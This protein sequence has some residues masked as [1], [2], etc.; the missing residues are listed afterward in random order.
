MKISFLIFILLLFSFSVLAQKEANIWIF[1]ENAGLDFNFGTPTPFVSQFFGWEGCSSIADS[2]GSLLF[3]SNGEKV[4]NKNGVIMDNGDSL[5]GGMSAVQSCLIVKIPNSDSLYYLFTVD[6]GENNG[7]NGFRYS[8]IDVSLNGGLGKVVLRDQLLFSPTT[9]KIA[10]THSANG[11]DV[12]V[13]GHGLYNDEFYAYYIDSNGIDTVPVVSATGTVY[14]LMESAGQIKVSHDGSRLATVGYKTV[15]LYN[16]DKVTGIISNTISWDYSDPNLYLYG[17]EFSPNSQVLY[18][19]TYPPS[20]ETYQYDLSLE[21]DSVFY[22]E[23]LL[24]SQEDIHGGGLQLAPDGKIYRA[25]SGLFAGFGTGEYL[26]VV[27]YPNIVGL[28]CSFNPNGVLL[29]TNTTCYLS[30]PT[31]IAS[32]L[33]I[34]TS[35]DSKTDFQNDKIFPVPCTDKVSIDF[36]QHSNNKVQIISIAGQL[37]YSST[38]KDGFAEIDVSQFACGIYFLKVINDSRSSVQT[39]VKQ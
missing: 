17:V 27:N 33:L 28:G 26:G 24:E 9:E 23:V 31:I 3:Y 2:N 19:S 14:N 4:W 12:W 8:L 32:S 21:P 37:V 16:F 38:H 1:G 11:A 30:L 13:I 10:A 34:I 36:Y 5:L 29:S 25:Y 15:R 6:H 7:F 20:V 22:S 39:I 18:V 35:I